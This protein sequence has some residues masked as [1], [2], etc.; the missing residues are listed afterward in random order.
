MTSKSDA[1]TLKDAI[2]SGIDAFDLAARLNEEAFQCFEAA[3][4]I[5]DL[6]QKVDAFAACQAIQVKAD[7]IIENA[8]EINKAQGRENSTAGGGQQG[9][10]AS[11]GGGGG[12]PIAPRTPKKGVSCQSNPDRTCTT[13]DLCSRY[14]KAV[15]GFS[16]L[17]SWRG[18]THEKLGFDQLDPKALRSWWDNHGCVRCFIRAYNKMHSTKEW[19]TACSPVGQDFKIDKP[20]VVPKIEA[21]IKEWIGLG[22]AKLRG[23]FYCSQCKESLDCGV[24]LYKYEITVLLQFDLI[25]PEQGHT[26]WAYMKPTAWRN[27]DLYNLPEAD[28]DPWG[29]WRLGQKVFIGPK[30]FKKTGQEITNQNARAY[31]ESEQFSAWKALKAPDGNFEE[32][33]LVALTSL[34]SYYLWVTNNCNQATHAVLTAFGAIGIPGRR[35][36]PLSDNYYFPGLYF[37]AVDARADHF[38]EGLEPPPE[39]L[40]PPH[41]LPPPPSTRPAPDRPSPVPPPILPKA[42]HQL[43][44]G[45]AVHLERSCPA[46]PIGGRTVATFPIDAFRGPQS[47]LIEFNQEVCGLC[48]RRFHAAANSSFRELCAGKEI[49]LYPECV[50]VGRPDEPESERREVPLIDIVRVNVRFRIPWTTGEPLFLDHR[51][52]L[53]NGIWVRTLVELKF[54][55]KGRRDEFRVALNNAMASIDPMAPAIRGL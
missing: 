11:G 55:S 14:T 5:D 15:D 17:G 42:V 9:S 26:A 25:A 48:V 54:E 53:P 3:D 47:L 29:D 16:K 7:F 43:K 41:P 51:V 18:K 12:E 8:D 10:Q 20:K 30:W 46:L 36:Y 49:N 22:R 4:K 23:R 31:F 27:E 40:E 45:G 6:N 24:A 44:R 35:G 52:K 2:D 34:N 21:A 39:P 32:A 19:T 50:S 28:G 1:K 37:A 13:P 38:G 33:F